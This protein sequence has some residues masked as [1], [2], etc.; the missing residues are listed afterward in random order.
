VPHPGLGNDR[1]RKSAHPIDRAPQH[2]DLQAVVMVQVHV[3]CRNREVVV[4][5]MRLG[6]AGCELALAVV[7][8]VDQTR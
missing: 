8:D 1:I 2:D 3:E 5:V 7:V 6:Q 4:G